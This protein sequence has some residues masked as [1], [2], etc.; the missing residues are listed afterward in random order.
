MVNQGI[1]PKQRFGLALTNYIQEQTDNGELLVDLLVRVV[2]ND[3]WMDIENDEGV[4]E[5][6]RV[7]VKATEQMTAVDRLFDR[8]FGKVA[9]TVEIET[10]PMTELEARLA[11]MSVE[12]LETQFKRLSEPEPIEVE[13]HVVE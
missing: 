11:D 9:L 5:K 3:L 10:L 13:G 7:P 1:A 6:L 2:K 12:E 8:G 4:M